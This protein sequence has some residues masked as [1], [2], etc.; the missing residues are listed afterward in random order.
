MR[1]L[2][3]STAITVDSWSSLWDLLERPRSRQP[4]EEPRRRSELR[5]RLLYEEH[6]P[7]RVDELEGTQPY[8]TPIQIIRHGLTGA[9]RTWRSPRRSAAARTFRR[10]LS[11]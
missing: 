6:R 3:V 9:S 10:V 7:E 2:F 4:R 1:V 11:A 8:G 5:R